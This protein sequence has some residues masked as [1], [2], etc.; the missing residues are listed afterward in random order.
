[1]KAEHENEL[2]ELVEHERVIR[3]REKQKGEIRPSGW[4][5]R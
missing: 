5:L 4:S 1:V 2:I 3:G